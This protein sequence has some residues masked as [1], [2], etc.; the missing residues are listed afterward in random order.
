M[1]DALNE[2]KDLLSGGRQ[3]NCYILILMVDTKK[4]P[5]ISQVTREILERIPYVQAVSN[6]EVNKAALGKRKI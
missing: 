3:S 2:D 1:A 5:G 4:D 6:M